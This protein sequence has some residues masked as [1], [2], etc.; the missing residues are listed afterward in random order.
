MAACSGANQQY[1]TM[2]GCLAECAAF[3]QGTI[4]ATSGD[5]LE[6]RTYHAGVAA[7]ADPAV[8]CVHAGP[9]GSGAGAAGAGCT[10]DN[11]TRCTAYCAVNAEVCGTTAYATEDE[12]RT[13]CAAADD[14]LDFNTG[15]TSVGGTA[16]ADTG[17][18]ECRTYHMSVA[19]QDAASATTHCPHTNFDNTDQC[20]IP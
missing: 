10:T 3:D 1:T 9:L 5:T 16:G 12:C 7:T 8:H 15:V 11:L 14:S 18:L 2:D 19:S 6:C 4:G 17:E 20:H 13:A